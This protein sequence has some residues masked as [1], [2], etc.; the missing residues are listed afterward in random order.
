MLRRCRQIGLVA[1]FHWTRADSRNSGSRIR[2][3]AILRRATLRVQQGV[4]EVCIP[5]AGLRPLDHVFVKLT[6]RPLF[7]DSWGWRAV[8][9]GSVPR[10]LPNPHVITGNKTVPRH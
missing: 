4:A 10:A 3:G 5:I 8:P 6:H 1:A 9:A 7:F 2:E